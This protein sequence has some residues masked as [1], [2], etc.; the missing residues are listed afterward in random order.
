MKKILKIFSLLFLVWTSFFSSFTYAG[1]FDS[2]SP[3]IQYCDNDECWLEEWIELTKD[4]L[5]DI[6]K[7]RR[8]SEYIQDIVIYILTFVSI[9]GVIYI[10]F[11][12]ISLMVGGWADDK[13][14]KTKNM[15]TYVFIGIFLMWLAYPI[16]RFVINV[17]NTSS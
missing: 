5:N 1:F 15:I 16:M 6:E 8:F 9:I 4:G 10:I 11:A 17:L 2:E 12:W 3:T 14:K 13:P 7:E